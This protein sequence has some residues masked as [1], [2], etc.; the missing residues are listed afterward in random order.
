MLVFD[1]EDDWLKKIGGDRDVKA[2]GVVGI[3]EKVKDN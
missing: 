1:N 2:Q 3:K